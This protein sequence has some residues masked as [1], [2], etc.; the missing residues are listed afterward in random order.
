MNFLILWKHITDSIIKKQV[1]SETFF[2]QKQI[3][4]I[5][6]IQKLW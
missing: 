5:Q 4:L 1:D 6:V 2:K 3:K